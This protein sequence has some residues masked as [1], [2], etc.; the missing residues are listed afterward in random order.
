MNQKVISYFSYVL[1]N[2]DV[3]KAYK[4]TT[5]EIE[6]ITSLYYFL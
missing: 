4:L 6:F 3:D 5:K 1:D 2:D